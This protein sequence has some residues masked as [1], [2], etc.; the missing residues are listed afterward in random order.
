[1]SLN[2][3]VSGYHRLLL[4]RADLEGARAA[5]HARGGTINDLVLAAVA[6]GA[7]RVLASRGE[8]SPGL[9]LRAS[10][11]AS[12]RAAAD[13]QATGNRVGVMIVPLPVC[14]P[15]PGRRLALIARA[16]AQRKRQ[17]PYQPSARLLQRWMVRMMSR[18][19]LVNLL[20]SNLPGPA[21]PLS[22]AGR[23]VLEIFQFGVVQGNVTV[24]VG[25][26]SY[27]GQL[28]LDLVGDPDAVS[29]LT[30]FADGI[31]DTLRRLGALDTA[32]PG[33]PSGSRSW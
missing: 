29:D 10:V 19:R 2:V 11:A 28:N 17:P 30:A 21:G 1:M 33:P 6:G 7:R 27:A 23:P 25:A 26:L 5:A 8:L 20:V 24:S 3:P 13:Q 18:Q 22:V 32:R 9:V 31:S 4:V 14:E 15:D 16:T 12:V